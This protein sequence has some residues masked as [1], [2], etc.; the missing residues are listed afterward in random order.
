ML[1]QKLITNMKIYQR[2]WF[3]AGLA[4]G[5]LFLGILVNVLNLRNSHQKSEYGLDYAKNITTAVDTAREAQV[6]FKIQVQE[7]KNTM[8]RGY[9]PK[10]FMK[11]W[12]SFNRYEAWVQ[13]DL[14]ELKEYYSKFEHPLLDV[15][16][17][18]KAI[19]EQK[20][21]GVKYRT[22][23]F[24]YVNNYKEGTYSEKDIE[25]LLVKAKEKARKN[26]VS[27]TELG[28]VKIKQSVGETKII[29]GILKNQ[30]VLY[31]IDDEV[32]GIDRKPTDYIDTLVLDMMQAQGELLSG[33]KDDA[34]QSFSF[35]LLVTLLLMVVIVTLV[36]FVSILT[37]NSIKKPIEKTIGF[38]GEIGN[39]NYQNDIDTKRIDELGEMWRALDSMQNTLHERTEALNA[40]NADLEQSLAEV[41]KLKEEQ[42]GDYF[43]TSLLQAPLAT[44][45]ARSEKFSV[46]FFLDQ[47]KKF[48]FR[49]YEKE[50]GGDINMAHSIKL[51]GKSFIFFLN[52]DA[53]GK[54]IQGAGGA[55][56]LGSV[57]LSI[58]ERTK[59]SHSV[60]QQ[61]PE[62]WLKNTFVE[63]H[64]VFE[65]FDGSMLM[66]VNMGL[67]DESTGTLYSINAEHPEMVL[68]RDKVASFVKTGD[69]FRKL[70]TLGV[71]GKLFVHVTRLYPGDVIF[72]GSDGRDDLL[73]GFDENNVRIINEDETL[74]LKL[75]EE[76]QG[77]LEVL[78]QKIK[79][80][81]EVTDDF[82]IL[83]IS[84]VAGEQ[85]TKDEHEEEALGL[86]QQFNAKKDEVSLEEGIELLKKAHELDPQNAD[87]MRRLVQQAISAKNY[88]LAA[89]VTDRY[90]DLHPE[91]TEFFY[92]AAYTGKMTREGDLIERSAQA[93]ERLRMRDRTHI[94]NLV[95]LIDI[96]MLRGD[97]TRAAQL[98]SELKDLDPS[99]KAIQLLED[100]V[101]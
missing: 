78:P 5:A 3:M 27:E 87:V 60:Q 47:K 18:D 71:A 86:L 7:W 85:V 40:A 90:I 61:Y 63:L 10:M 1:G 36:A 74:F 72:L 29:S 6:N 82:S 41:R 13:K 64:K 20:G 65:S 84:Y 22:A 54:S 21:L 50:L 25:A 28:N 15:E 32:R 56:V 12:E 73:L 37:I 62:R 94:K 26:G 35:S 93:G 68:Y 44:N 14:E 17:V 45:Y 88:L 100:K 42:D 58:I 8:L 79:A 11:Y 49:K 23:L 101:V 81:G 89:E 96:H 51:Q 19:E 2:L 98:F 83:K 99:H 57:L 75:V 80:S 30:S 34:R 24:K 31:H 4:L 48:K 46:E 33:I 67:I 53:M 16:K 9:D 77:N 59:M 43:L 97:K 38:F 52:G 55:L 76:S 92:V 66:S 39:E 91:D 69:I 70:G 95:N